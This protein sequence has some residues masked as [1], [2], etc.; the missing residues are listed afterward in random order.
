MRGEA[1]IMFDYHAFAAVKLTVNERFKV[2]NIRLTGNM[3]RLSIA[4][5]E[6]L[7]QKMAL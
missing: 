4:I 2:K 3:R 6:G 1:Y 5:F 7:C